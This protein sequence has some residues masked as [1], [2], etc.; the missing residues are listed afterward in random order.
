MPLS[1]P[2]TFKPG[3]YGLVVTRQWLSNYRGG[4]PGPCTHVIRLD[5]T[6]ADTASD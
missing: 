5:V 1:I 4:L 2:A 3:T 6:D